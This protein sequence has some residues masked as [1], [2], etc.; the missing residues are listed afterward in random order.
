LN[1]LSLRV[2]A[3]EVLDAAAAVVPVVLELEQVFL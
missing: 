3:A 2:A 1:T